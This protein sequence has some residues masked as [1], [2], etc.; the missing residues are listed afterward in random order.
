M[1][2]EHTKAEG[3]WRPASYFLNLGGL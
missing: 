2:A 1:F 3:L